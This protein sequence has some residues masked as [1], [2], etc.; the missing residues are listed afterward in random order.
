MEPS[1]FTDNEEINGPSF[2]RSLP[3]ISLTYWKSEKIHDD[4]AGEYRVQVDVPF[5]ETA[6]EGLWARMSQKYAAKEVGIFFYPEVGDEVIFLGFIN[7]DPRY[8]IIL[9]SLYGKKNKPADTPKKEK[10][11]IKS[12]VTASKIRVE[13]ND[14]DK[15]IFIRTPG[16]QR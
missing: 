10:N 9:G 6:G 11:N 8:A 16:E 7:D 3:S 13:F 5:I 4:P 1:T 12:I 15:S 2:F 14:E